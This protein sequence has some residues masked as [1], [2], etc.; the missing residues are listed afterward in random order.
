MNAKKKKRDCLILLAVLVLLVAGIV[1]CQKTRTGTE[2]VDGENIYQIYYLNPSATRLVA[3]DYQTET[4]DQDFLIQELME[5]LLHVPAD[6]DAQMALSDKVIYQ[7]YK[8]EDVVLYLYFDNNYTSMKSYREILCRAA[9]T[10]T[11]TQIDGIDYINIY[12]GDQPLLDANNMPVGMLSDSD[13]VDSITD[14]NAYEKTELTLYFTDAD[15]EK[16]YPERRS[17][18]HNINTSVEK[19]VI[20]ALLEGPESENL[21]PTLDPQT[22]LLN[23]SVNEN[24]C[25]LNF[26]SSFL[27]NALNV[28]DY[29]P[30]YSIVD[31]LLEQ[32]SVSRVQITVD[33]NQNVVFRDKVPLNTLFERNLDL[34]GGSDH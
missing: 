4:T 10:K 5:Q 34:I 21:C 13:F 7:G 15:G 24:V 17:V 2:H 6:L 16:L 25:Y 29:I 14:I 31:S 18:M 1:G 19:V 28:Q 9:L 12:T 32:S 3:R 26:D 20:E 8:K 27:N 11:M 30:I 23:I 33:G 22:K